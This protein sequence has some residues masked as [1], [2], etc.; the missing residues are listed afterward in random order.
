MGIAIGLGII[1]II[2]LAL[3]VGFVVIKRGYAPWAE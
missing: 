2:A 3:A 1:A